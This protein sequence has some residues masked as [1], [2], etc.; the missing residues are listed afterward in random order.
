MRMQMVV[1]NRMRPR[2]DRGGERGAGAG[3]SS[4]V[5]R[6]D[7]G[8]GSACE[9]DMETNAVLTVRELHMQPSMVE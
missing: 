5:S 3:G 7:N 4:G 9:E 2:V 8:S 6:D 1:E